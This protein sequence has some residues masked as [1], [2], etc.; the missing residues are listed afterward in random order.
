MPLLLRYAFGELGLHRVQ[1]NVQPGNEASIALVRGAGFHRE[2][3]SP[4][5]LSSGGLAGPRTVGDARRGPPAVRD[6]GLGQETQNYRLPT[7]PRAE[8]TDFRP[9]QRPRSGD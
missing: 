2:G 6:A 3:F 8:I 7:A 5:Y 9:A 4:R 1:A